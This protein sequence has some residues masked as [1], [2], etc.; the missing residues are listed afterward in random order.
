M[1]TFISKV[2]SGSGFPYDLPAVN[3]SLKVFASKLFFDELL[4]NISD[5]I[6]DTKLLSSLQNIKNALDDYNSSDIKKKLE[7]IEVLNGYFVQLRLILENEDFSSEEIKNEIETFLHQLKNQQNKHPTLEV[8]PTRLIRY[9]NNLFYC[10]DDKR[11]PRTNLDI[12]HSFNRL[13]KIKRKRTGVK[14]SPTYF[15]HEAKSL[16][17]IENITDKY[18]DDHSE[19][20]FI[21]DFSS[22]RLLVSKE[23]LK[24]QS[25]NK[26]ID[27]SFLKSNYHRKISLLD[28]ELTFEK[29]ADKIKA[30]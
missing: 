16:V 24:K 13:K 8:I 27:K 20:K 12:E 26:G 25:I 19:C 22:K 17:Q 29:L 5:K 18:K 23:Q 9:W 6:L 10:Y 2:P 28:A 1:V 11:I 21:E 14:N 30:I 4:I 15:S 3:Y 7:E